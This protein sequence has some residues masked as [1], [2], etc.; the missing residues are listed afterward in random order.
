[1]HISDEVRRTLIRLALEIVIYLTLV[2]IYLFL[3]LN[4]FTAPLVN[5]FK[6]NLGASAFLGL[7]LMIFQGLFLE[8][9]TSYLLDRL[10]L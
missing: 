3:I 7:G 6:T 2:V 9:V 5:L 1:M 10:N 8:S 4:F